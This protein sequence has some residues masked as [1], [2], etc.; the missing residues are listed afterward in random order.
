MTLAETVRRKLADW[1]PG[2]GRQLL[3]VPDEGTG[4]S[5]TLTAD[6]TDS[7]GCLAWEFRLERTPRSAASVAAL[8]GWAEQVAHRVTGL[9]EPLK[10]VEVDAQR[11]E[12][13][14]RSQ[15]PTASGDTLSYYEVLLRGTE[16]ALVRRYRA[17]RLTETRR[18]QVAFALTHDA[19]VKLAIDLT[20]PL[21]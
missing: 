15:E 12:A 2:Q 13:L 14:L 10:V 3:A 16:V 7:L 20:A 17:S 8:Q 21:A 4:W 1:R 11:H 19:L 6:R 5:L 18:E 9:L